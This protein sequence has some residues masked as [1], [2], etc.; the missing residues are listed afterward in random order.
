MSTEEIVVH[1][2]RPEDLVV[3]DP[4][5]LLD[6]DPATPMRTVTGVRRS[7]PSCSAAGDRGRGGGSS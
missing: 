5:A 6:D 4:R 3:V 2:G 7:S 1:L